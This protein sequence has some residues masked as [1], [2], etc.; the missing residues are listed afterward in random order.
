LVYLVS[1]YHLVVSTSWSTL[2][3]S[4]C[5]RLASSLC[6][7]LYCILMRRQ[8]ANIYKYV[9]Y[10]NAQCLCDNSA[11][12]WPRLSRCEK[13]PGK[14]LIA[15][16]LLKSAA[17][18]YCHNI[19]DRREGLFF[20]Y[21]SICSPKVFDP[22]VRNYYNGLAVKSRKNLAANVLNPQSTVLVKISKLSTI[23][24]IICTLKVLKVFVR[25]MHWLDLSLFLVLPFNFLTFVCQEKVSKYWLLIC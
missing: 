1:E 14:N 20:F 19:E 5:I 16:S 23:Y 25:F 7:W 17:K 24:K 21:L 10:D 6:F 15:L 22:L 3:I 2:T 4:F 18:I 12:V 9:S 13:V 8:K 11:I